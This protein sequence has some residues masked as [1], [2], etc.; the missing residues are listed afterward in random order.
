MHCLRM[1]ENIKIAFEGHFSTLKVKLFILSFL[2]IIFIQ[3]LYVTE[4][5]INPKYQKDDLTLVSAYYRI[6]SKH[7]NE[8]YL[9]WINNIVLL[10]KS[11]VFFT[12][13]EFMPTLK[14]LRPKE[15]YYKTIFIQLEIEE[16]YSYKKF[17]KDF[18][19]AF[20]IDIE[21]KYHSVPLYI[22]WSEKCTFLKK[23][24]Q[25]NYFHSKCFYWIDAGYFR[26]EKFKM[27]KY[28]DKWPSTG[29]C[30]EDKRLLLG[31][32][33]YFSNSFKEKIIKFDNNAHHMLQNNSNVAAG[34]FG[35][36]IKNTLKFIDLYY[37][38]IKLF[39]KHKIFIGKE[40]NIFTFIAFAHPDVVNL[41]LC[42]TY[43][44]FKASLA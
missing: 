40:Q 44:D 10:N 42:K 15:L 22:V 4:K 35:G 16:F 23:V 7:S 21:N 18:I 3:L 19:H 27:K 36:Q 6:K 34:L 11:F 12:N 39:I 28:L 9:N 32:V 29:K 38:A 25:K 5:N 43:Y 1:K 8:S 26:E 30:Y 14:K 33:K 13:K 24:I 2:L 20:E 37:N 41:V 17:Y 31:Q